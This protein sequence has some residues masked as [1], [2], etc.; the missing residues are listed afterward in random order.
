MWIKEGDHLLI[1]TGGRT[2]DGNAVFRQA[3][4]PVVERCG[5]N[6]EGDSDNLPC[7]SAPLE[8]P[9][10]GKE[11]ENG[12]RH[13]DFI[14]IVEMIGARIIKVD[15]LLDQALPQDAGIKINILLW[16][17]H[18]GGEMMQASNGVIDHPFLPGDLSPCTGLF[19]H[20]A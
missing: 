12:P 2:C 14:A 10:P 7:P 3:I 9:R 6:G 8:S 15:G 18:D 20:S 13:S 16:V 17:C 19:F 5:R 1:E 4:N 11:G